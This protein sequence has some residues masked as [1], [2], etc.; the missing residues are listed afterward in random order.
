MK[1]ISLKMVGAIGWSVCLLLLVSCSNSST[2]DSNSEQAQVETELEPEPEDETETA[3]PGPANDEPSN[4]SPPDVINTTRVT[5]NITVPAYSS[6]S[7]LVRVAWDDTILSAN[8]VVDESWEVSADFEANSQHQLTVSF[9]D[10]NGDIILGTIETD[11][12]TGS[13]ATMSYTVDADQFDSAQWDTDE[14]GV[15]NLDESIAA[16][17]PLVA[18]VVTD[19]DTPDPIAQNTTQVTFEI[20]VPSYVSQFLTVQVIW[21]S[22]EFDAEWIGDEYWTATDI[23]PIN[24]ELPLTVTFYDR[25]GEIILGRFETEFRTGANAAQSYTITAGQFDT[26]SWDEDGDGHSNID[27]FIAGGNPFID[28]AAGIEVRGFVSVGDIQRA[29]ERYETSIPET[30]PYFEH[31]E[32]DTP[33]TFEPEFSIGLT[34]IVTIDIDA[35]GTGTFSDKYFQFQPINR[36][37]INQ[38]ATRTFSDNAIQWVGEYYYY[39]S[40][41]HV[42][43]D[44]T[45]DIRT[46]AIDETTRQQEGV[47]DFDVIGGSAKPRETSY[48]LIGEIIED[49]PDCQPV[50]GTITHDGRTRLTTGYAITETVITKQA[51]EE[52]WHVLVATLEGSILEVYLVRDLGITFYCGFPEL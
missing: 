22:K 41:A 30:R 43:Y 12:A 48:S 28:E 15:S 51:H 31:S 16:T 10:R 36:R 39:D 42:G 8:W 29:S 20:T 45:F 38:V 19:S 34:H 7:L 47:V 3:N 25:Q 6:D 23:F 35:N 50:S 33:L 1:I 27:E 52:Y 44:T 21:G 17:D 37:T 49:T 11:F 14:D 40:S 2:P 46:T 13:N 26:L 32:V 9:L 24:A 5:F 18:N 4:V